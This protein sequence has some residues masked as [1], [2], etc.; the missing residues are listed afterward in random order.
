MQAMPWRVINL[1]AGPAI[2][3]LFAWLLPAGMQDGQG[4]TLEIGAAARATVA[5]AVWMAW[6][7]LSEPVPLPV[8]SL[9]PAV[10]FPLLGV[11]NI[12][13]TLAPYADPLL[14]LFLGG[15]MLA[16][17]IEKWGLHRRFAFSLL[18][19]SG[20]QT[21]RLVLAIMVATAFISC[22][23][24]N[25]A[26]AVLMF[27]VALSLARHEF[28]DDAL[29]RCLILGVAYAATIGGIG[30]LIGTPPN[31]YV[32]SFLHSQYHY[33]LDFW[34][35][36][37][38]GM[39]I[40]LVMLPFTLWLL[41][42]VF[43]RLPTGRLS[44][45]GVMA[46]DVHWRWGLLT[47]QARVTLMVFLGAVLAWMTRG[48]LTKVEIAGL[49]PLAALTDASIAMVA[50]ITL[51]LFPVSRGHAPALEWEDT[52]R[53]P[54]GTLLLFGGGLSLAAAID[55]NGVDSLLGVALSGMP[56]YPRPVVIAVIAATVI[57]VSEVASN[58][59]TAAALT[60]LLAAVAPAL[61]LTPVEVAI[62]AGL[63]ASS[64]YMMPVGTAPNALAYGSGYITTRDMA[65]VGFVMNIAS[66]LLIT[67][68]ATRLVPAV[69]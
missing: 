69:L 40:V 7:W 29:R 14:F 35:W 28:A 68:V 67:A 48:L 17:A 44:L 20:G 15:F 5:C 54:W 65:G 26:T 8:T 64:A 16:A 18:R 1:L 49:R 63:S 37:A 60:P 12:E 27:P 47:P 31:V 34:S 52:Q 23:L 38:L 51:Y 56:Q 39:P 11:G 46:G 2:A 66:V 57:F 13:T 50:A 21:Q 59:A 22:W 42:R 33:T 43:F 61:G 45:E 62:I 9:V 58:I 19:L 55:A 3:C 30:T 25:T 24:S 41:T 53:L 10:M 36:M 4:G 6:W 32:S